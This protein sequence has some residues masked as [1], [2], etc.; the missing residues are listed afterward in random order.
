MEARARATD[1]SAG[2]GVSRP[3]SATVSIPAREPPR[4]LPRGWGS[5]AHHVPSSCIF[6]GCTEGGDREEVTRKFAGRV[7]ADPAA[8]PRTSFGLNFFL[9]EGALLKLLS[10]S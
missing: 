8:K 3:F 1:P 9:Q 4:P 10:S 5:V 2:H 7:S 6:F